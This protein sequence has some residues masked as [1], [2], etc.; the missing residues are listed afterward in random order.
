VIPP[1]LAADPLAQRLTGLDADQVCEVCE[2]AAIL[3]FSGGLSRADA[4]AE[5]S[6]GA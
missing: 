5:A 4:E 2:R 1:W 6:G 3:E